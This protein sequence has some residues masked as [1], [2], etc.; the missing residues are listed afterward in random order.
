MSTCCL[1]CSGL[2]ARYTDVFNVFLSFPFR[3]GQC[4]S[5]CVGVDLDE[6][7][8]CTESAFSTQN[9]RVHGPVVR[10]ADCRSAGPCGST[11]FRNERND[12]ESQKSDVLVSRLVMCMNYFR[13]S[14]V[15]WI[16]TALLSIMS[17]SVC[18]NFGSELSRGPASRQAT[19][20]EG[21][22]RCRA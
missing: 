22:G 17:V 16:K 9:P 3:C 13:C 6:N 11:L 20:S 14:D 2:H 10:A 15:R 7:W 18:G 5:V 12:K 1:V 19:P 4:E 21:G 8:V